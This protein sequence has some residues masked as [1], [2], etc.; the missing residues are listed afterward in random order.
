[1]LD[2]VLHARGA[3]TIDDPR[4]G[5]RLQELSRAYN[6]GD[7]DKRPP[8]DARI[9]FSFARDVPKGAAASEPLALTRRPGETLSIVD[10]GA[11]LG[12]MTWGVA[13]ALF[14]TC[15]E[16]RV[17]ALLIDDD[18]DAL[19]V[20]KAI[21]RAA[22]EPRLTIETRTAK[23]TADLVFAPA[24]LVIV[25]QVLSELDRALEPSARVAKHADLVESL[26]MRLTPGGAI[27]IVEPAL[28]ERTRHLH[29][30]RD[31]LMHNAVSSI[32]APCLHR[33]GCP[34]LAV[35]GE[36]CHDD[37]AVDLPPWLVP[38][39]RSAGLRWQ[40]MTFSHLVLQR[41][42]E[43]PADEGTEG[44]RMR[45]ISDLLVTKGKSELFGCTEGGTRVRLRLLD[46]DHAP[47]NADW[48]RAS[49]GDELTLSI[50]PT[51]AEGKARVVAQADVDVRRAG[52]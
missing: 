11:G 39:A 26:M 44:F 4:M 2:G 38:L 51:E 14:E 41:A 30:V 25:G 28:R 24:D 27:M 46:R 10:V 48:Y 6:S 35:G 13:R 21:V 3:P 15:P 17:A 19:A 18:A 32:V 8:L 29:A 36:W 31:R 43:A 50:T 37:R 12:A 22:D 40:R 1:M 5:P 33:K 42:S 16:A 7:V 49:R 20:A 47:S 45:V 52:K 23:L 34:A 9:A